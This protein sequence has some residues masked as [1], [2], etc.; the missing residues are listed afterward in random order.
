MNK[1]SLLFVLVGLFIQAG[2]LR[3]TIDIKESIDVENEA[4]ISIALDKLD[5]IENRKSKLGSEISTG[6]S[7]NLKIE[8]YKPNI[9]SVN[10]K[11]ISIIVD[12][13]QN[14]AVYIDSISDISTSF[15]KTKNNKVSA[16]VVFFFKNIEI[17]K[18]LS[19]FTIN[20]KEQCL[21]K[22]VPTCP[23]ELCGS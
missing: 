14:D 9:D 15:Y 12:G 2:C 10:L 13:I 20:V 5:V 19:R 22:Y 7:G 3:N 23:E 18:N 8:L 1:I 17:D 21:T 11:C 6:L 4:H 16:D